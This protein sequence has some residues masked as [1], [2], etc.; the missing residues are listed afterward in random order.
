LQRYTRVKGKLLVF[1]AVTQFSLKH[2]LALTRTCIAATEGLGRLQ[3][4]DCRS[5][6][7]G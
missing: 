7:Y 2:C 6:A 5:C 1:A 3:K 4:C